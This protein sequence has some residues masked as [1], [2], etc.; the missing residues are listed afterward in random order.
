MMSKQQQHI[1]NVTEI[2]KLKC[3]AKCRYWHL[4]HGLFHYKIKMTQSES[5]IIASG[6]VSNKITLWKMDHQKMKQH[7]QFAKIK[8]AN[9]F[10]LQHLL[11]QEREHEVEKW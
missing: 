11:V 9:A 3:R 8:V 1:G 2:R 6:M 10:S 7:C 5:E 4:F